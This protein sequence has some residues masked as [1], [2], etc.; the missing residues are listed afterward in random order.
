M[1]ENIKQGELFFWPSHILLNNLPYTQTD[2]DA[3]KRRHISSNEYFTKMYNVLILAQGKTINR[4]RTV[5][6]LTKT[7]TPVIMMAVLSNYIDFLPIVFLSCA[8]VPLQILL[9][10]NF[11]SKIICGMAIQSF[12]EIERNI[13]D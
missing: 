11:V 13:Q 7:F 1:T 6:N 10:V 8:I 12:I 9:L 5:F 3:W 4:A 2:L